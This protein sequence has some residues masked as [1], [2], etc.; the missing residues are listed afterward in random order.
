LRLFQIT[1]PFEVDSKI[2]KWIGV[3]DMAVLYA[4]IVRILFSV[5]VERWFLWKKGIPLPKI[6]RDFVLFVI[7]AAIALVVLRTRGDVNLAGIITTSAVLTAS[8][9]FAAQSTL[10]NLL[11][12]LSI[13]ADRP[14][15]VGDWI[16]FNN[17]IGQVIGIGWKTTRIRTFKNEVVV[18]PNAGITA[19]PLKNFSKPNDQH[20]LT[21][22]IG[23]E[24]GASPGL[25]RQTLLDLCKNDPHIL[26][27][28]KPIVRLTNYGDFAISYELRLTYRGYGNIVRLRSRTIEKIWYAFR[29]QGI[30]IPFP[31]RDVQHRHIERRYEESKA[32][33]VRMDAISKID[34]LPIF[35][36]LSAEERRFVGERVRIEE[37]GDGED[38]VTQSEA[39]ES[40]YVIQ[41]GACDVLVSS[42]GDKISKV[43]TI[44]A[45]AIFG[46]MSLL[47]GAPRAATVRAI[48]DV[49]VFAIDK[50]IFSGILDKNPSIA[51]V[52]AEMLSKRQLELS[53]LDEGLT[54]EQN[55][56]SRIFSRIKVFFGID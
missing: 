56:K 31:I 39:G 26:K 14:F 16:E 43:A 28:P 10:S 5:L 27:S 21:I 54:K 30:K 41:K 6:T 53:K 15:T 47:T 22:E 12:G 7:Y 20:V 52:L 13:Q 50:P 3:I 33:A 32:A 1:L 49:T 44:S 19:S 46:E 25:V 34:S 37:F 23:V 35:S 17:Y 24:Y 11:S 4:A 51:E 29:R 38:I 42:S 18:L 48:G 40:A 45:P 8:I 9:G 55:S 2:L 36:A